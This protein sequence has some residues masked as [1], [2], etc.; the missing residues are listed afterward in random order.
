VRC[1]DVILI[2]RNTGYA[3]YLHSAEVV[4]RCDIAM[5]KPALEIDEESTARYRTRLSLQPFK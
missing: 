5:L 3:W 4:P 2:V 1:P